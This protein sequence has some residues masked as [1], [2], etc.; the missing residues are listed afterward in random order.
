MSQPGWYPDPGG[1]G[2]PRYW[3]G[4]A[5]APL[6][7]EKGARGSS[8]KAL[9]AVLAAIVGVGLVVALIILR[10]WSPDPF[11]MP[12]DTNSA[13]PTGSQWNEVEPTETPTSP[14]PTDGE[15]RPVA[16]PYVDEFDLTPQG[17]WYVS[18]DMR[19]RAVPGWDDGGGWTLDFASERSGQVDSVAAT[20]VAITAIGQVSKEDFSS[21]PRTAAQQLSDC[22]STSYYYSTLDHRETLEDEP[23]TTADGVSGWLIR[24]NFWN[25]PDQPVIGDEIVVVVVDSGDPDSLTLFHSQAPIDDQR[26]KDLVAEA[27]NSLSRN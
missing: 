26:R 4:R 14:Q 8:H 12:T 25:I 27:L 19:F 13:K 15:G 11:A 1:S 21:D 23:F 2:Q 18:G 3:D 20:W 5:W 10:P 16:C 22:M 17:D 9:Y 7:Q 24:Q 6:P